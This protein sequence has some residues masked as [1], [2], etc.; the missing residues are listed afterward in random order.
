MKYNFP[1]IFTLDEDGGYVAQSYDM[2][3]CITGGNTFEEALFMAEDALNAM[4][5][6]Y[7]DVHEKNKIPIPTPIEDVKLNEGEIVKM[8]HA[9]TEAYAKKMAEIEAST[10]VTHE[11]ENWSIEHIEANI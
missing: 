11:A 4:L 8:I 10:K 9:D 7:E 2:K 1:I 5:W 3:N 6:Y